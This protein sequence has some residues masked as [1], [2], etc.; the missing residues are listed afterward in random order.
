MPEQGN[1]STRPDQRPTEHAD[2]LGAESAASLADLAA[3][4]L[5]PAQQQDLV[6]TVVRN[7]DTP[8]QQKDAAV[9]AVNALATEQRAE[10]ADGLLGTPD[11]KTRQTLWYIVVAT[12]AAAIFIFG[13]MA[14]LLLYQGKAAEGPL[15]LA[16]TALGGVV[17]LVAT[18]PGSGRSG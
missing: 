11:R 10:V 9:A 15:A 13:F 16:T 12:L 3:Q 2:L 8:K 4:K 7:L 1:G 18:S 6:A 5:E 17:G 14:F